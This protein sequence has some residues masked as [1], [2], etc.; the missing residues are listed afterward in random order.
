M[1]RGARAEFLPK[2][3]LSATG[4]TTLD[5]LNITAIP[6]AGQQSAGDRQVITGNRVSASRS[7]ARHRVPV[8]DGGCAQ[9]VLEQA[10]AQKRRKPAR[11]SLTPGKKPSDRLSSPR[12]GSNSLSAYRAAT[13]P[14][15]GRR[16]DIRGFLTGVPATVLD[17]LLMLRSPRVSSCRQRSASTDAYSATLSAAATLS[18]GSRC[19]RLGA[20][21]SRARTRPNS[22]HGPFL[23]SPEAS[24]RVL[25]RSCRSHP[26][27]DAHSGA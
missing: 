19:A 25:L 14:H 17:R 4:H 22:T 6:F 1:L 8:Y 2:L 26:G 23:V 7:F 5:G 27:S 9:A 24:R 21:M 20:T 15:R 13:S 18:V 16:D 3:F 12:T 11:H 10:R